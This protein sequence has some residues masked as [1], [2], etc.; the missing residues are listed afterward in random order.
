MEIDALLGEPQTK[1]YGSRICCQTL[2]CTVY[3]YL[4]KTQAMTIKVLQYHYLEVDLNFLR[5]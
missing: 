1:R 5:L 2:L 4:N 3:D